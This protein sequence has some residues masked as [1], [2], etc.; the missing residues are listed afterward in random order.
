MCA[1]VDVV[2]CLHLVISW[3]QITVVGKVSGVGYHRARVGAEVRR[4]R[5]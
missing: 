4:H 1:L 3:M 2:I 5:A